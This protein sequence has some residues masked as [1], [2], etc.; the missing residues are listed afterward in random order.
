MTCANVCIKR[1]RDPSINCIAANLL[2]K[3]GQAGAFRLITLAGGANNRVFQ[4]RAGKNVFL[5]KIYFRDAFDRRDRL[6]TEYSFL[7]FAWNHGIT[8]VP[9][10]YA[11]DWKNGAA[12]YEFISGRRFRAGDISLDTVRQAADFFIQ[13]NLNLSSPEAAKLPTA[14]EACFSMN[15]HMECVRR[16]VARLVL[17]SG[18]TQ[19]DRQAVT[20]IQTRL[21]PAWQQIES[22]ISRLSQR[23]F[24]SFTQP[25]RPIVRRISPSDFGFHNAILPRMGTIRFI[26][27]EY[28]GWDD[29]AKTV[30]DFFCQVAMPVPQSFLPFFT[31]AIL[32][33]QTKHEQEAC[34]RRIRFLLPL[35]QIKW[36]CILLNEFL[37]TDSAR[38]DFAQAGESRIKRKARQLKKANALFDRLVFPKEIDL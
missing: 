6:G 36:G 2:Q 35:Y 10:P 25:I 21:F 5:L 1:M 18:Q 37:P 14:S 22:I 20:F 31:K 33:D 24:K 29:P 34:R 4:I 17:I 11:V 30:C 23:L 38:R 9:R 26:D 27:F 15:E 3:V 19:Y 7:S 32:A 16:R 12:L 28:A 13:M 8:C